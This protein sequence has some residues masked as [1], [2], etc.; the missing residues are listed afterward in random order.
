MGFKNFPNNMNYSTVRM[1]KIYIIEKMK[2]QQ[3]KVTEK[4]FIAR[5]YKKTKI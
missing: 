4:A 2:S 5:K 3:N 1:K